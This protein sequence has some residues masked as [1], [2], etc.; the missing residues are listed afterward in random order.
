MFSVSWKFP[1]LQKTLTLF[2]YDIIVGAKISFDTRWHVVKVSLSMYLAIILRSIF[3]RCGDINVFGCNPLQCSEINDTIVSSFEF[4]LQF[5]VHF[6]NWI[7]ITDVFTRSNIRRVRIFTQ[8]NPQKTGTRSSFSAICHEHL[9]V[10][11][12]VQQKGRLISLGFSG[13]YSR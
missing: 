6:P 4:S 8:G 9:H 10:H 2:Y 3:G 7:R 1:T 12:N 5:G 11:V 13:I